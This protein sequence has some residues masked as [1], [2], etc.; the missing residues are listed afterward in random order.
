MDIQKILMTACLACI[1][2]LLDIF[3]FFNAFHFCKDDKPYKIFF[4]LIGVLSSI[5]TIL[6]TIGGLLT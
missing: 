1:L 3:I 4:I 6:V 2:I 5:I